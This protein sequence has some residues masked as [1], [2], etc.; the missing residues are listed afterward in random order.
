MCNFFLCRGGGGGRY[1]II[2][3]MLSLE[4]EFWLV[5]NTI[6]ERILAHFI[7]KELFREWHLWMKNKKAFNVRR[8][9]DFSLP[10]VR[11]SAVRKT[12]FAMCF[13][14]INCFQY[15]YRICSL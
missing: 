9:L 4:S 10:A 14:E 8:E 3:L 13:L 15:K 1:L 2:T 7:V 5:T 12:R 11:K 6:L